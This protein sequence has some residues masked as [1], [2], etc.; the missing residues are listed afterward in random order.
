MAGQH[1]RGPGPAVRITLSPYKIFNAITE[2]IAWVL[3]GEGVTCQ[4]HYL[5]DFLFLGMP[6]SQQGRDFVTIAVQALGIPIASHKTE[7]HTGNSN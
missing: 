7:G 2:F 4:L 3:T 1:L 6:N 5:D